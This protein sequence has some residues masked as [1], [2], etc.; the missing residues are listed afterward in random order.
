MSAAAGKGINQAI[1]VN[2]LDRFLKAPDVAFAPPELTPRRLEKPTEFKARVVSFVPN[3][4]EPSLKLVLQSGD[5]EPREFPMKKAAGAWTVTASPVP[6]TGRARRGVRAARR[7][8]GDRHGRGR[9]VH[10]RR[11]AVAVERRSADRLRPEAG[12]AAR[13]RPHDAEGAIG[14]LGAVELDV[15]G[16]KA[17]FDLSKATQISVQA[18][19]DVVSVTATVIAT[20]DG[21]EVARTESRIVVR[22]ADALAPADPA[23]V[24]ITPPAL[25]EDKVV[26]RLPEAFTDVV[27]GGGGRYLIFH[28]PKLKKLAVF[29]VNEA[30]VTKYIPLTEEDITYAAGLDCVVIGLKKAGKLERWSLTTFELEKSAAPP[31]KE[32]IKTCSWATGRTARWW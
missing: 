27:V 20:V 16:Q 3:A 24:A 5:G 32:D 31:F 13:G 14:G 17:K 7:G 2:R 26:K 25:S 29:D 22:D 12:R 19:P 9:G 10:G 23:T 18:A 28:M 4:P 15:G 21:K 30:R 6:K 11:Q 8:D 1:P